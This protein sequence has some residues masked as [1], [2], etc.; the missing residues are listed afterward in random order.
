MTRLGLRRALTIALVLTASLPALAGPARVSAASR[1]GAPPPPGIDA[2]HPTVVGTLIARPVPGSVNVGR[3]A[4]RDREVSSAA[5]ALMVNRGLVICTNDGRLVLLQLSAGT[6]FYDRLWNASAVNQFVT[7]DRIR[8]WGVPK[9]NGILVAPTFVVQDISRARAQIVRGTLVALPVSGDG[10]GGQIVC[11]DRD[12]TGPAKALM[13]NRGLVIC[14]DAG[15]L[16][17][18]QLSATTRIFGRDRVALPVDHLTRG[19][20]IVAWGLL[21]DSGFLLAPTFAVQDIDTQTRATNSQDYIAGRDSGLTLDVLQSDGGG[22]VQG[23]VH[24]RSGGGTHVVLCGGRLGAWSNLTAGMTIDV[25]GSVF[26]IRT[27]TYVDTDT[28]TVVNCG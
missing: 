9:D 7:G 13:V 8:A 14:S 21:T 2:V 12:V 5:Q 10:T 19:D 28:V 6:R 3:I 25:S 15:R 22:P 16:V 27:M 17:L 23:I 4:C 1:Q 11:G 26:D 18:L 20:R 24:A